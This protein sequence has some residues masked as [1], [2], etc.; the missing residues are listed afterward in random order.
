MR[1]VKRAF[2]G[3]R[4]CR[5]KVI[6]RRWERAMPGKNRLGLLLTAGALTAQAAVAADIPI[7]W[8]A[9]AP[10]HASPVATIPLQS[11]SD[12]VLG[13]RAAFGGGAVYKVSW[14]RAVTTPDYTGGGYGRPTAET[15]DM[16]ARIRAEAA[17]FN[18]YLD[19]GTWYG[20]TPYAG[21]PLGVFREAS[22]IAPFAAGDSNAQWD[23]SWA[24]MMGSAAS[25][26]QTLA[27][28]AGDRLLARGDARVT[29]SAGATR[30]QTLASREIRVGVRWNFDDVRIR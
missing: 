1:M 3:L 27:A 26:T 18:G 25:S 28:G 16:P 21:A 20:L 7:A 4:H 14:Q 6:L 8:H 30:L 9:R 24:V 12:D 5:S 13:T 2:T 22:A 19:L 15:G 11:L 29:E 17:A 23:F 10:S